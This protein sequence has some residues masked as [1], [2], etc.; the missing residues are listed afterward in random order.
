MAKKK[1]S[2]QR[3]QIM[4]LVEDH[5]VTNLLITNLHKDFLKE[6]RDVKVEIHEMQVEMRELKGRFDVHR[7]ESY[8]RDA[9]HED[10]LTKLE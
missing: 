3:A 6:I 4:E 9:D 8:R 7:T 2:S 10:R 1:T 5:K